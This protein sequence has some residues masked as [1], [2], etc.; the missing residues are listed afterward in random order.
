M[1]YEPL[2]DAEVFRLANYN[3]ERDRG[4]LHTPEW[5]DSMAGLQERYRYAGMCPR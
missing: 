1:E 3:S 5:Q 2:T 4:L